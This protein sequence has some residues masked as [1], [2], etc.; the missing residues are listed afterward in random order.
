MKLSYPLAQN[1]WGYWDDAGVAGM[2]GFD[3][4]GINV[5]G[6]DDDIDNFKQE[7]TKLRNTYG[8]KG[9]IY[10]WNIDTSWSESWTA[11]NYF[12]RKKISERLNYL[13]ES[14]LSHEHYFFTWR[15]ADDQFAMKKEDG[16]YGALYYELTSSRAIA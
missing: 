14:G 11:D 4:V 2:G 15:Y 9:K 8:V 10:E 7:I 3:Y 16:T 1:N 6:D 12:I 5:Y 13:K